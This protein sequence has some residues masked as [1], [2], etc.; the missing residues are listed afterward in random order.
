MEKI[1]V[2]GSREITDYNFVH[3]AIVESPFPNLRMEIVHGGADG[4]DS[5]A[6]QYA[7]E[8]EG[9]TETIFEAK[10]REHGKSAGPIRNSE[11]AEYGDALVAI[12]DGESNGTRNMIENALDASIPVYVAVKEGSLYEH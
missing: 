4:V 9:C 2:S 5:C 10:W 12:W 3:D 8:A 11:M 7:E 6:S 1:V